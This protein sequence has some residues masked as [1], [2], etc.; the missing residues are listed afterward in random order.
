MIY[1]KNKLFSC[2][3]DMKKEYCA[4]ILRIGPQYPIKGAERL[5]QTYVDGNSVVVPKGMYE[6]GEAVVYC[7]NETQLNRNF[8]SANNQ[9]EFS[10]RRLNANHAEVN[11]LL[12]EG[13]EEEAR[14]K[15]GFFN[16]HGRVRLIKLRGCPSYGCIFKLE[17]LALWNPKLQNINLEDY[18]EVDENGYEHPFRFDSIDGRLF[19]EVYIPRS[20][21][22]KRKGISQKYNRRLL[23]FD[24]LIPGQFEYHYETD[25]LNGNMWRFKPETMITVSLKMH[26][27]SVCLANVLTKVPVELSV[28]DR[29][30]N[31]R[32]AKK[33]KALKKQHAHS[34]WQ[35]MEQEREM[36]RLERQLVQNYRL[37]Y[38]AVW[39]SRG[40]IKNRYINPGVT[41]GF[42]EVD[43]Y[44][45]YGKMMQ[46]HISEGLTVYGEICGYLTG[47]ERMVMKNYDYGCRQGENFLMPYRITHTAPDGKKTEWSVQQ[48]HDWTQNLLRQHPK[49]SGYLRPIEILYHGTLGDLY[50]TL[51]RTRFW[52][53][54][55]L[56][57][58][59]E[60]TEHFGME[61]D[62][63][64]CQ[65]K[66]PR[67][68][69]C[70][71]IDNDRT[72]QCFKLK[73]TAFFHR[74]TK[75]IDQGLVDYEMEAQMQGTP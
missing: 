20:G 16:K 21:Q 71:R 14:S 13:H 64:L 68:G 54:S 45:Q 38:G 46:P 33:I 59:K 4:K 51:D 30:T 17:Q 35:R 44:S 6:S 23:R 37:A 32:I 2:S 42:Y 56:E 65:H 29:Y 60:D 11:A 1:K 53:E 49:L 58:I 63:P 43:I 74:E 34:H 66:V 47:L 41:E 26:G 50:P 12:A 19:A 73:T 10:E 61:L 27:T 9:F 24:R 75:L 40:V 67:E 52:Q 39:S 22:C 18:L 31:R 15:V 7:M 69:I 36:L 8:L 28:A 62:E 72:P 57:A 25:T 5:V 3:A 48:V 55:V 70:I